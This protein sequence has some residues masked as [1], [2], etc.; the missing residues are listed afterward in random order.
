MEYQEKWD[1]ST[2]IEENPE[3]RHKHIELGL[4]YAALG[5]EGRRVGR[6]MVSKT[7]R[8]NNSANK[9]RSRTL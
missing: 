4:A 5:H 3:R 9:E 8:G 7:V 1:S 2:P 6:A